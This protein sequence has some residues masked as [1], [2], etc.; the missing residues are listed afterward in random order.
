MTKYRRL[1]KIPP[2]RAENGQAQE[3]EEI[4]TDT[5]LMK[6]AGEEIMAKASLMTGKVC[7]RYNQAGIEGTLIVDM[8]LCDWNE[9]NA[10]MAVVDALFRHL[11]FT[12]KIEP[13]ELRDCPFC[14]ERSCLSSEGN[15]FIVRCP[16]CGAIGPVGKTPDKAMELWGY[17][18][19]A[20][21]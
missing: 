20:V 11:N 9:H 21:K 5:D 8:P 6:K 14:S 19:E 16:R 10:F 1:H 2:F 12:W 15:K 18:Q 4:K 17:K 7:V 13:I 3:P